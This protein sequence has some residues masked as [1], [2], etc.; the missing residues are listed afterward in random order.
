MSTTGSQHAQP[1]PAQPAGSQLATT[2]SPSS[3]QQQQPPYNLLHT[4]ALVC[5]P[6][7]FLG[8][9]LPPRRI[10][11]RAIVLGS[12]AFWGAS[13]LKY[14]YTGTSMLH[15]WWLKEKDTSGKPSTGGL[16]DYL[17]SDRAAE[18]SRRIKEEKARRQ[19]TKELLASGMS[20]EDVKRVQELERRK[21]RQ[22]PQQA[23]NTLQTKGEGEGESEGE[24]GTL[25]AI[26]MGDA[27][28]NWR[29]ERAKKEQEALAEGGE[30]IWGL[31]TEQISEVYN[32]GEK[33]AQEEKA[34]RENSA[35]KSS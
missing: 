19:R 28:E 7:A 34:K 11:F 22:Q 9:F 27:K 13:Q 6:V 15:N 14:D 4:A 2:P 1:A 23:T 3:Q 24:K 21:Q 25:K 10:D 17:P 20:E 5:T 32:R 33:K 12:T 18:V 26:W 31:I 29:E 16:N 35:N 8:L 30:G